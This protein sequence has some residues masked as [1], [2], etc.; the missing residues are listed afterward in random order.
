VKAETGATESDSDADD[1]EDLE[2]ATEPN[3]RG[4]QILGLM[5]RVV[6]FFSVGNEDDGHG[7]LQRAEQ[8]HE[9]QDT[10]TAFKQWKLARE[11]LRAIVS[12]DH[13]RAF[14]V[15]VATLVSFV[16]STMHDDEDEGDGEGDE[17]ELDEEELS[18][19]YELCCDTSS[20]EDERVVDPRTV[21]RDPC[22]AFLHA[23][24]AN[25]NPARFRRLTRFRTA[26]GDRPDGCEVTMAEV[27]T[28]MLRNLECEC[29]D[30]EPLRHTWVEATV[31][32]IIDFGSDKC[33]VIV[34]TRSF[35]TLER[36]WPSTSEL[37]EYAGR[38]QMQSGDPER[39]YQEE[40][41]AVP[42]PNL[43]NLSTTLAEADS[44]CTICGHLV[45]AGSECYMLS[46]G[47]QF[48]AAD[49]LD[50][51]SILTWLGGNR[52]CPVCR[53]EVVV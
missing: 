6:H 52:R 38:Q 26:F 24:G 41:F 46:C 3:A 16:D 34:A 42:T 33:D 12:E 28:D 20:D 40:R 17:D 15:A 29:L 51:A 19:A 9:L 35:F 23:Q 5:S 10:V 1:S 14:E 8:F 22:F 27:C 39:F 53:V 50:G 31:R 49:C 36:R 32:A 2:P 4:L 25:V 7:W 47:H 48:H 43:Q 44:D 18:E 11:A 13:V 37:Q 21:A 45:K 30:A